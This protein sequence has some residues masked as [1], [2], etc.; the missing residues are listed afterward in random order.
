MNIK[1]SST[2][3]RR[4]SKVLST[5]HSVYRLVNSTFN[6]RELLVGLGRIIC[7]VLNACEAMLIFTEPTKG[8][9]S[10]K[11]K[12][13]S[14]TKKSYVI[15]RGCKLSVLEKR[16]AK[17]G[18]SIKKKRLLAAPLVSEDILGALI[19]KR[20]VRDNE[21][22]NFD[23]ESIAVLA[24]QIV[25]ALHN[26]R[27]QEEHQKLI[28]GTVKSLV[29]LLDSKVPFLY[30]HSHNF[31]KLV[32]AIAEEL[33]LKEADLK[34][35]EYASMLHDAGKIDTPIDILTKSAKLTGQELSIIRRHPIKGV[36]LVKH[37]EVLK[38]VIPIILHHHERFDG[39]GYPSGLKKNKIPLGARIMAVADAFEAMVFGRP[40]RQRMSVDEALEE[41]K[42]KSGTQFDPKIVDCFIKVAKGKFKKY[43]KFYH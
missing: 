28:W 5:I 26:M 23:Q 42:R 10:F 2:L 33:N 24:E 6:S 32:M 21:F 41:I 22:D 8:Y 43:L 25:M 9:V 39:T 20:K 37:L 14:G 29:K 3:T 19:V 40:Y 31:S 4:Y 12:S 35:L 27:L 17:S 7:S 11:F 13:T 18:E 30:S 38:P 1:S 36:E 34:S 15:K 16:V